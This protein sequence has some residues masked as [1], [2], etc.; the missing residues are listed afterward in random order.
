MAPFRCH[1]LL[2]GV[3]VQGVLPA[4]LGLVLVGE[5]DVKGAVWWFLILV[6]MSSAIV[7]TPRHA[8]KAAGSSKSDTIVNQQRT[9]FNFL[10][11]LVAI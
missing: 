1:C 9:W 7:L 11:E 6:L 5:G 4:V 8:P 2:T 10:G 3:Q